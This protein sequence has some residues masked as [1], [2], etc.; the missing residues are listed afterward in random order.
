MTLGVIL[1][2]GDGKAAVVRRV[3]TTIRQIIPY[4][5]GKTSR[6]H[7][8]WVRRLDP[9]KGGWEE[10]F[11]GDHPQQHRQV[12]PYGEG[13]T[14]SGRACCQAGPETVAPCPSAR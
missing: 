5:Y 2:S 8:A 9:P 13:K 12:F 6:R 3:I 7:G 1:P 14:A 4:G 10:R 11:V